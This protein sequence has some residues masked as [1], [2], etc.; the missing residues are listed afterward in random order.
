MAH[1]A[2]LTVIAWLCLACASVAQPLPTT[3]LTFPALT[4]RVVDGAGLLSASDRAALTASLAELEARTTDQVVVVTLKSLQ[5]TSI[6]DYGYQLGRTW[7]IGQKDKDSGA[8]LIVSAAERQVRIEVGYG[9]EGA[10]TDAATKII[11][12]TAILPA[13]R[14]GD[15][16][17]GIRSG[18]NQIVQMLEAD[19]SA[20][21]RDA[22]GSSATNV[23]G[24][25]TDGLTWPGI[26]AGL[27]GVGL[28]I[29]C[30]IHGGGLCSALIQILYVMLLSGRGGSSRG[31]S[32]TFSGGGGS[33]GGGG[34]SG[35]W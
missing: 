16:S 3:S 24:P 31:Q 18:V 9:L 15:F 29:F 32:S 23:G 28:L 4:G 8:L 5:G 26:I 30:A 25:A 33:F 35:S 20:A 34:S 27:I 2:I 1:R 14:T 17:G 22:A 13:F 12:E 6:E 19:A 10:L 7:Q 11:I 21:P